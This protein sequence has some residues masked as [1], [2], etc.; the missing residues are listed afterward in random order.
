[1]EQGTY[2]TAIEDGELRSR[3]W[4]LFHPERDE[5]GISPREFPNFR[6]TKHHKLGF[7][8]MMTLDW[9]GSTVHEHTRLCG[10]DDE[11]LHQLT[12]NSDVPERLMWSALELFGESILAYANLEKREGQIKYYPAIA[13]TFWSGFEAF[14]RHMS[15]LLLLMDS[16]V[17]PQV[18]HFLK[19]TEEVVAPS[20][21][22]RTRTRY[23]SVLDRYSVFL[24]YAYGHAVDRGA[25][26]WQDLEKAK[27][28]RDYYTHV[29][30]KEPREISTSA[31]TQF[32]EWVLLGLV[33][34][35]SLL[36]RSLLLGQ[37]H[38][39]DIWMQLRDLATEYTERPFFMKWHLREPRMFHCNFQ[40][41]DTRFPSVRDEKYVEIFQARVRAHR[42]Q[43]GSK[44]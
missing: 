13:L 3:I 12:R 8:Y 5:H 28:L 31:M 34:P 14:V 25:S 29:N 30:A 20:G 4:E 11:A 40:N 35:S 42:R 37:F 44:D 17:P 27:A 23:Q 43:D 26:W 18:R 39:Y 22:I 24:F 7:S 21:A 2:D 38:L 36:Q 33:V 15:E 32:L 10:A 6:L 16:S 41:V 1:M 19:E 9:E